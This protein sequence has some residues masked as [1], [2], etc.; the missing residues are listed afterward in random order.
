MIKK[1]L[2]F[3]ANNPN[4]R[5]A[6][7]AGLRKLARKIFP[8]EDYNL[9]TWRLNNPYAAT[10]YEWEYNG[11]SEF[12]L[13]IL[14]D[15]A[16]YHRYYQSACLDFGISYKVIDITKDNWIDLVK[17]SGCIGFVHWIHIFSTPIKSL[18][19]ERL[20]LMEEV[21]KVSVYP[22]FHEV[23]SLDNKRRLRDW[24]SAHNYA[25]PE[26]HVFF[27]KKEA[28]TFIATA[29][30]PL[31]HKTVNGSVSRGVVICKK[32]SEARAI[33]KKAFGKGVQP[34]KMDKRDNQWGQI[35]FQEY[36]EDVHERRMARIGDYYIS[37]D[38]VRKGEFHSGSGTMKWG[39]AERYYLDMTKDVSEKGKFTSINVDFFVT[40]DGRKLIN[41]MH[42]LFHG[43]VIT[44][45]KN[46]GVYTYNKEKNDWTFHEGNFYRNYCCNLRIIDLLKQLNLEQKIDTLSW[47]KLPAFGYHE[48]QAK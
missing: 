43:P 9:N 39:D 29:P 22:R 32:Q 21:L 48:V 44:D 13:G 1:F 31:V 27:D 19:D 35:I 40:K 14:Y 11:N 12:K 41:E 8:L 18:F 6:T 4:L 17:N 2:L 15:P 3:L 16:H 36:L 33:I 46:K 28:L 37:I 26:T 10:P 20:Q 38:K 25:I 42:S 34:A 30:F 24:L 7:P 47:L 45:E 5:N 23:W